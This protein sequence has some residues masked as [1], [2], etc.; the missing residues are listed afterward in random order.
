ME[1]MSRLKTE[2]L[3]QRIID[4]NALFT[5]DSSVLKLV[6]YGSARFAK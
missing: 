4:S 5:G 3:S 1:R 6:D 2:I